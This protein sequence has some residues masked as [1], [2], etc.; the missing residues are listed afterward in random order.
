MIQIDMPMPECCA[1]CPFASA[2][3]INGIIT[4]SCITQVGRRMYAPDLISRK[5][6]PEWCPLKEQEEKPL[7]CDKCSYHR[8]DGWCGMHGRWVKET[9]YCSL[10]AWEER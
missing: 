6:R 4:L 10:G 3:L 8:E 7:R 2:D 5:T 1:D 9:D